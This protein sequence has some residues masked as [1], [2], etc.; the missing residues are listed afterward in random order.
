MNDRSSKTNKEVVE[1]LEDL[2]DRAQERGFEIVEVKV[3]ALGLIGGVYKWMVVTARN[4][5]STNV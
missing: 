2:R 1:L 3:N 5:S 4:T